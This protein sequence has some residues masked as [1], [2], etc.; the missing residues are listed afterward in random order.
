MDQAMNFLM[1][2]PMKVSEVTDVGYDSVDYFS[3]T[4]RRVYSSPQQYKQKHRS[5]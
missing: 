1:N 2:T 5:K 3:R 4:F